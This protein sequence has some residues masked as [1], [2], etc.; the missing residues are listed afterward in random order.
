MPFFVGYTIHDLTMKELLKYTPVDHSDYNATNYALSMMKDICSVINEAKR[1]V[2]CLEKIADWQN[3]VDGWE[4]SPVIDLCLELVKEG[5]LVKISGGNIQERMF[6]LFDSL[7][8][9]CRR[10]TM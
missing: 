9:Y 5:Q 2:E 7:L 1:R 10:N 6:F 8:V 3:T 4:G